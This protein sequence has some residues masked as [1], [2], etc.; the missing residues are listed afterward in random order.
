LTK[1]EYCCQNDGSAEVVGWERRRTS[2]QLRTAIKSFA[3]AAVADALIAELN[4]PSLS[5]EVERVPALEESAEP[6]PEV[7][8][9]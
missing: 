3:I 5:S 9:G 1:R 8:Y 7:D 6:L 4:K 2:S